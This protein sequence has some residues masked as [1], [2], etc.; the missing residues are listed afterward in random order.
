[1]DPLGGVDFDR[2]HSWWWFGCNLQLPSSI[3]SCST[4]GGA[5]E[6]ILLSFSREAS[7]DSPNPWQSFPCRLKLISSRRFHPW[8]TFRQCL[9]VSAEQEP[10]IYKLFLC[11][12]L[13]SFHGLSQFSRRLHSRWRPSVNSSV[14]LETAVLMSDAAQQK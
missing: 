7:H 1:M 9:Q 2:L 14:F 4:I 11:L 3:L 10:L 13:V 8:R 5:F 12:D 6:S